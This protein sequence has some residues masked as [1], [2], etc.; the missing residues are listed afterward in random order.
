MVQFV[1]GLEETRVL[2]LDLLWILDLLQAL[3]LIGAEASIGR[4]RRG[5]MCVL[6]G[7]PHSQRGSRRAKNCLLGLPMGRP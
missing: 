3:K 1:S 5:G 7:F 2:H 4:H 6:D